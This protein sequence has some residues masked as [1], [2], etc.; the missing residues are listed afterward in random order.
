MAKKSG[1][2]SRF[3]RMLSI[4]RD[5]KKEAHAKSVRVEL[6]SYTSGLKRSTAIEILHDVEGDAYKG[7]ISDSGS[8]LV[9][10]VNGYVHSFPVL[11]CDASSMNKISEAHKLI[12]ASQTN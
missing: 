1:G 3:S 11:L 9:T 7:I 2:K 12:E 5:T 8:F 6:K 4:L 10:R